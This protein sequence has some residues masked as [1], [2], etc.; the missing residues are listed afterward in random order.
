M[1]VM[2]EGSRF[3]QEETYRA[4]RL[5]VSLASTL[6]PDAYTSEE[7]FAL[8]RQRVFERG[9]VG[10]ASVSEVAEP[11]EAVVIEL[12]GRSAIVVRGQDG[13]LRAFENVCRHRGSR[14]LELGRCRLDRYIKCP[15]HSW[16]YALDGRLLGT[17][18]F[19][20]ESEVPP[21]QR[22]IFDMGD[23]RG[24]DKADYG[25]LP[26]PVQAWG[27]LVFLSFEAEPPSL[28]H[29]LG[30]LPRRL[31][32]YGLDGFALVRQKR[33]EIGANYKLIAENFMEYYHLPLVHPSLVKVSPMKAHHRWQGSGMYTGMCT[34]PIA[35][36]TE[37]GGW[38]GLPALDGLSE[39]DAVSA[40]FA[41]VFPNVGL[42]VLPNQ[43]F[44]MLT[45]PLEPGLTVEDTFLL[46]DPV[47]SATEDGEAAVE[48][49]HAFWDSVNCEDIAIVERVQQGLS[50]TSYAG[51]RM[52]YRFEEPLH[53]F[54]N[55]VID[56]MVGID[57]VP[58]GDDE[59]QVPMFPE[60]HAVVP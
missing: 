59:E 10:A 3:T 46:A 15:Y 19:T 52:C 23:V 58:P 53:R 33:Y 38:L 12:A 8:E 51:G 30:D 37:D 36:D 49:L 43:V 48:G 40:R 24:F 27:P 31:S 25:L 20:A 6:E 28:A 9:W 4:T 42:N 18:L 56:R 2:A 60:P 34:S 22:G 54:Q 14:L 1:P 47:A 50:T 13:V 44:V 45:R 16:A 57:R 21:D 11:G 55:M 32:G 41:W 39:S 17:P 29:Q 26:L 35:A 5:P 7:F